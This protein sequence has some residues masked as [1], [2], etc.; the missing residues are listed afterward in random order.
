MSAM[1]LS[2][3]ARDVRTALKV[4]LNILAEW[5]EEDTY[6]LE[7]M[8]QTL[9]RIE[10]PM[11]GIAAKIQTPVLI[12]HLQSAS[13][14][15]T[16]LMYLQVDEGVTKGR[17]FI[18]YLKGVCE[19]FGVPWRSRLL[20][21][22]VWAHFREQ[23]VRSITPSKYI[24]ARNKADILAEYQRVLACNE[25]RQH[26]P[27]FFQTFV[28]SK[29]KGFDKSVFFIARTWQDGVIRL[30]EILKEGSFPL[31]TQTFDAHGVFEHF[32]DDDA[33]VGL[34]L[35][36]EIL[37]SALQHLSVPEITAELL[38]F[39]GLV[40]HDMVSQGLLHEESML[41]VTIKDKTRLRGDA[42]KVS[43]HFLLHI[44][45][46]KAHQR[47]V[48]ELLT[49]DRKDEIDRGATHMKA[50]KSLPEDCGLPIA[51]YAFDRKACISNG[52]SAPFSLKDRKDP[53]SAKHSDRVYCL[54]Q[55][56]HEAPCPIR[57]QDLHGETLTDAERLWLLQEQLYTTPKPVMLSYAIDFGG[58]IGEAKVGFLY[59]FIPP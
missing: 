44:C 12:K 57:V 5:E 38:R 48:V 52:F 50:N 40:A 43:F 24:V 54:G 21:E 9:S 30:L 51:W 37:S 7:T 56:V 49:R 10:R 53:H 13:V 41:P 19:Q 45:A 58:A 34:I 33:L 46:P 39:P 55:L 6:S 17:A 20:F 14:D 59:L 27:F 36:S 28:T 15:Y 4:L 23:G 31:G 16:L 2:Q 26:N 11:L 47:M 22:A 35:D 29:D 42:T 1:P 3:I 18:A 8:E 25:W 32:V